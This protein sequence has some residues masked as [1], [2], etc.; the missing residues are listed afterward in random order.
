MEAPFE[1][2]QVSEGA[3]DP[4]W[5]NGINISEN[6]LLHYTVDD[7]LPYDRDSRFLCNFSALPAEYMASRL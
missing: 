3:S 1:R 6:L 5:L 4:Q 2:S 7:F